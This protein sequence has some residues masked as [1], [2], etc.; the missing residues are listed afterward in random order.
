MCVYARNCLPKNPHLKA[1]YITNEN[2]FLT[3]KLEKNYV[4]QLKFRQ[5]VKVKQF[6][7]KDF[8]N[9]SQ[10]AVE[11]LQAVKDQNCWLPLLETVN[12]GYQ[13]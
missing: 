12:I 4:K 9:A 10:M 8:R 7:I 6:R 13:N 3:N 2:F 5:I 11:K 1:V